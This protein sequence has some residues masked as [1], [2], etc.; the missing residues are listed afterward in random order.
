MTTIVIIEIRPHV[1]YQLVQSVLKIGF[2]LA[3]RVGQGRWVGA[4]LWATVVAVVAIEKAWSG[5]PVLLLSCTNEHKKESF[6]LVE[7]LFLGF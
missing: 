1:I 6:H 3:E 4:L 7:T 2:A 5:W